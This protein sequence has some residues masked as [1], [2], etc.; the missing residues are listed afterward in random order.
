MLTISP[1]DVLP[2]KVTLLFNLHSEITVGFSLGFTYRIC[3]KKLLWQW[4][5]TPDYRYIFQLGEIRLWER[6][7]QYYLSLMF[8][9]KNA[10]NFDLSCVE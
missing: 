8:I 4:G 2:F 5:N 10:L 1:I 3:S 9:V 6:N 7:V